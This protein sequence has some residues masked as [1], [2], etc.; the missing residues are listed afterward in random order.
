MHFLILLLETLTKYT[1]LQLIEIQ[2][3]RRWEADG[4]F[5]YVNYNFDTF[6]HCRHKKDKDLFIL[7]YC[8]GFNVLKC[9]LKFSENYAW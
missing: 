4:I 3:Q 1:V 5:N 2:A 7:D 8:V 9:S 6:A